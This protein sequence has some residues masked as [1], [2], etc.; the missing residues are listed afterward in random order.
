MSITVWNKF[1]EE[2]EEIFCDVCPGSKTWGRLNGNEVSEVILADIREYY[3]KFFFAK[4]EPFYTNAVKVLAATILE[5][6][7]GESWDEIE[8]K[9]LIHGTLEKKYLLLRNLYNY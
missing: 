9:L 2:R 5:D 1:S 4:N 8:V 7:A 6:E 3:K